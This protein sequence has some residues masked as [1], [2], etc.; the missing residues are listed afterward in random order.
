MGGSIG[1]VLLQGFGNSKF[2]A[3]SG[4]STES[5]TAANVSVG[6]SAVAT[7]ARNLFCRVLG[8]AAPSKQLLQFEL[9]VNGAGTELKCILIAGIVQSFSDTTHTAAIPAGATVSV[10]VANGGP[11]AEPVTLPRVLFGYEVG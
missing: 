4:L 10:I 8:T 9:V 3:G 2:L 11:S 7:T 1:P 6:T 5:S